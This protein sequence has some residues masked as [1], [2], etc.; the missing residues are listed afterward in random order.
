MLSVGVCT[1]SHLQTSGRVVQ[2]LSVCTVLSIVSTGLTKS[3]I[4]ASTTMLPNVRKVIHFHLEK[5][6][7]MLSDFARPRFHTVKLVRTMISK[8]LRMFSVYH[9]ILIQVSLKYNFI[10]I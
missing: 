7:H 8:I 3:C 10:K 2:E 1:T 4:V 9:S 6:L 5:Y